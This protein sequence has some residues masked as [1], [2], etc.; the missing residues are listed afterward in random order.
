MASY[1]TLADVKS[2]VGAIGA[3]WGATSTPSDSQITT[4]LQNVAD[5]LNGVIEGH[6]LAVPLAGSD[7]AKAL[8]GINADGAALLAIEAAFSDEDGPNAPPKLYERI[9]KRYSESYKLLI[10]GKL[11]ALQ[12]LGSGGAAPTGSSLW[13]DD[14]GYGTQAP[15]SGTMDANPSLAPAFRRGQ[16]A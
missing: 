13:I 10:S 5:E 7:A 12:I 4:F 11:P 9:N 1:A 3:A 14:P 8:V 15:I 2:R 16:S 6:G